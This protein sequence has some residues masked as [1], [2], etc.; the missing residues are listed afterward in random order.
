MPIQDPAKY[1]DKTD[2]WVAFYHRVRRRELEPLVTANLI[3]EHRSDPRGLSTTASTQA[4][5]EAPPPPPPPQSSKLS[6]CEFP[7]KVK[8]WRVDN[9]CKAILDD[10][11]LRM[12]NEPTSTAIVIGYTDDKENT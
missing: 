1:R 2:D 4:T 11:A 3:A 6:E 5:V 7:N 8:P 12:K 10:V 9:T